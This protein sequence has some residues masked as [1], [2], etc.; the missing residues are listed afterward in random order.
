MMRMFATVAFI[1]A[2][3]SMGQSSYA[4]TTTSAE[5]PCACW[6]DTK[7]GKPVP[8]VPLNQIN[9]TGPA[10]TGNVGAPVMENV[11]V[12]DGFDPNADH[13]HN[14]R[15]GQTFSRGRDGCWI[16]T[17]TGKPVPTVP[18]SQINITG[19]ANT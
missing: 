19:P 9:I 1:V 6:I 2:A 13:A 17:K 3:L 4:Q 5:N 12:M 11:T 8:T 16:D 15:T 14:P 18:L 10:N 7:T